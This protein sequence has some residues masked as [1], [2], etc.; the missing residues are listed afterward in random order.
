MNKLLNSVIL[1]LFFMSLGLN[2]SLLKN[3]DFERGTTGWKGDRKVQYED[4]SEQNKICKLRIGGKDQE[5]Y[6]VVKA[7]KFKDIQFK[8]KVKKSEDYE[9]RDFQI[10]FTRDDGSYTFYD[11]S[12]KK[13][14]WNEG[15]F[16]FSGFKGSREIKISIV[17]NSGEEGYLMFDD[18]EAVGK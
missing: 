6:Q 18:I 15:S 16:K 12:A 14:G 1:G 17:V 3:G 10:R 8:Y 4:E 13:E 2:A 11:R 5:F 7:K 9:G